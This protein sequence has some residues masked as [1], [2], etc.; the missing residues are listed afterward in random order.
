MHYGVPLWSEQHFD[1]M[2]KSLAC[3]PNVNSREIPVNLCIDFYGMSGNTQSMVRWIKQPGGSFKYDFSVFDKYLDLVARHCG[4]PCPLRLNCWGE[5]KAYREY[6]AKKLRSN[7]VRSGSR[8]STRRRASSSAI[9]SPARGPESLDFW[10][11]VLQEALK[12]VAARGWSDTVAI[13]HNS[14][15]Y[16]RRRKLWASAGRSGRRACGPTPRTTAP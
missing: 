12:R 5:A 7:P 13:G 9:E 1:L 14:Y 15:C 16:G 3:W 4:R 2:G 6:Q 11:P 10:K 8:C